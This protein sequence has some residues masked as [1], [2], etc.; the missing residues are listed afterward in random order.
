M[1]CPSLEWLA[2]DDTTPEQN[3][4]VANRVNNQKESLN[5]HFSWDLNDSHDKFNKYI[6]WN[7][8]LST[9]TQIVLPDS[10]QL[11]PGQEE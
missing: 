4:N 8:Q 1:H 3:V 9:L 7:I 11:P 2:V 10:L 5:V 6:I